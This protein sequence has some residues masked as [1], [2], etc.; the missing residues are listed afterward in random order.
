MWSAGGG[1]GGTEEVG[2]VFQTKI[3]RGSPSFDVPPDVRASR[4]GGGGG[5][6]V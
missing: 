2:G 3:Q 4:G 1:G 6:I 5:I